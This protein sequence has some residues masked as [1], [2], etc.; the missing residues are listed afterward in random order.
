[1]EDNKSKR[2]AKNTIFLYL[3]MIV[4][5]A[6]GLYTSRVILCSL[7]I[8]DYGIYNV[9]GGF[10]AMFN[11]I[12]TGMS[13]ATQRFITYDIGTGNLFEANRTFSSCII[14]YSLLS[15][16]ILIIGES[17]GLWFV[18]T[19]L[20]LPSDR[21]FATNVVYQISLLTL[22]VTL[23]SSPYNA[24]IIAH[25]KMSTFAYISIFEAVAKLITAY[26]IYL[27]T[28]DKL[29][30]YSLLLFAVALL[31]RLIYNIYCKRH[32]KESKFK[33]IWDSKK[34]KTLFGFTGWTMFGGVA[35]IGFTQGV[36]M[37]LG[38]FW[39]PTINAAR[40]IAVQVQSA[41]NSFVINFQTAMDPQ[42][43]K[44]YA[45]G[46]YDYQRKLVCI[47]SR[48]SFYLL[49]F[50]SLPVLIETDAILD[51]WLVDVPEYSSIFLRLIIATTF[52][53]AI[54]NPF[55][56]AIIATGNIKKYQLIVNGT[57]LTIVPVSYIYLKFGGAAYC[58]FIVHLVL[59]GG[60]FIFRFLL[61]R[62][63]INISL[64]NVLTTVAKP[65]A[66]VVLFSLTL[67]LLIYLLLP[68]SIFRLIAILLLSLFTVTVAVYCV[69]IT[70][71]ERNFIH[72][73]IK[74]MK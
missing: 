1:M 39:G 18:N 58:V 16:L 38:V 59:G 64:R 50:L 26:L 63:I 47:S 28:F 61:A 49:Y 30:V 66:S 29:I 14:I 45:Q 8:L 35:H 52:Y 5:M 74:Q 62:K 7:G 11:I 21:F 65:I 4:L 51:I 23:I 33:F 20:E 57:L 13:A 25:E 68:V 37:L 3:R 42:I 22:I 53:D 32:F 9:V 72:V 69:G 27:T 73:K 6:I 55:G 15:L 34:L 70:K 19:Q 54:S 31:V 2:I 43:I 40:G 71:E 67:P 17:I 48:F 56:K 60:A 24:L 36:N 44:S 12:S 41:I 10:V 46:D